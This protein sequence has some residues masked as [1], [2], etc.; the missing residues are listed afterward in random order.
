MKILIVSR[1]FYPANTPRAFRTIEIAKEFSAMGHQVTVLTPAH[2]T[3]QAFAEKHQIQLKDLGKP[4]WKPI[5][6][7]GTGLKRLFLRIQV[8]LFSLLFLYPDIE[9]MFLVKKALKKE[10]GKYDLLI[11][12]AAPHP[13]HWGTAW[14]LKKKNPITKTWIAD[15][16][17]PFMGGENDT[18]K[19]LFYF[20]YFEKWFCRK[21]DSIT[22]PIAESKTAYYEEF[23]HKINVIPQGF[24]FEDVPIIEQPKPNK[25]PTFAYAGTL[26]PK[27]RDPH[28]FFE[29]ICRTELNF[30]F[31]VYTNNPDHVR[32]YLERSNGK[33]E[34]RQFLPR[35]ELLV[36]LQ[37]MDFVVNFENIGPKQSPSKL[38]DYAII[39]K[40]ILSVKTFGF[41]NQTLL[42]FLNGDYKGQLRIPEPDRYR[43][44]NVCKQFIHL[45][46]Q[47]NVQAF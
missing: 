32:K 29:F 33:I 5:K 2:E 26:I 24:K 1:S 19:R 45:S 38:I 3:H 4:T 40:P 13:V 44:E 7:S 35:L 37:Q 20:K 18:F 47:I 34:V 8:R 39:K 10:K 23:R 6:V 46:K 12:I 25:V 17:D 16:G 42:E 11:S 36:E 21:A 41:T 22:V 15:C 31:I 9:S 27:I 30:K 43:I 28:E 14:A